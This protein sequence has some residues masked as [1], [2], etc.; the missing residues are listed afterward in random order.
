MKS[1]VI[2][3]AS[4]KGGTGK[5]ITSAS[6]AKFLA[7]LD[8]RVLLIDMDAA[9]N[10]LSLFYL[11]KLI[12]AKKIFEKEN[13]SANGIY[14]ALETGMPVSFSIEE[15]IDLIP[16]TYEMK[17]TVCISDDNEYVFRD[18]IKN[19]LNKY[20]DNYNYIIIDTQA[21]TDK[22]TQIAIENSDEVVIVS[23]YDPISAQGVERFKRLFS[24]ILPPDKIWILFNKILPEFSKSLGEFLGI[25]RYL[26]PI[27]WDADV[28]RALARRRLA[29]DTVMGNDY[30]LAIM[31]TASSLF[32]ENL[33]EEI[34]NWRQDKEEMLREPVR[35]QL[36]DIDIEIES[37]E[38]ARI[39]TEY[40]IRNLREGWK[41]GLLAATAVLSALSALISFV[42]N[43]YDK[44]WFYYD[45]QWLYYN[46]PAG[47]IFVYT[48]II[49]ITVIII[50]TY[51]YFLKNRRQGR[52]MV[53]EGQIS[54][55]NLELAILKERRRKYG[56][57]AESDLKDL[58]KE[59]K[60]KY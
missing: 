57:L 12:E 23:E 28:V 58:L 34:Y 50:I 60:N 31:Q 48:M 29:I 24:D 22:Y 35:K 52:E 10:G 27:P 3:F 39:K 2:C 11:E 44:Y 18:I 17:Q 26:S 41:M 42:F 14:E 4:A 59:Y 40:Q 38:K 20:C 15:M 30:T 1:K 55:L 25:A 54:R 7:A 32:G 21:G 49:S 56:T 6:L 5:T 13:R 43:Y 45:I 8:K 51:Q 37:V 36:E 47:K 19:T 9:T 33:K 53:L 46:T 16:A